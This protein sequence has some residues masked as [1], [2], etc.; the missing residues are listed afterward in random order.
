MNLDKVKKIAK[1]TTNILSIIN[2]LLIGIFPIWNIN[3]DKITKT[4]SVIIAVL[5][6]YLLSNKGYNIYKN[7]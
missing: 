7:K 1:Y 4:I 3:G 6:A 5:G 2:A